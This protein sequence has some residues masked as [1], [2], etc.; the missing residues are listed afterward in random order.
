MAFFL[1]FFLAK[2]RWLIYFVCFNNLTIW[3]FL[4]AINCVLLSILFFCRYTLGLII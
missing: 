3:F 2:L 4:L 1:S